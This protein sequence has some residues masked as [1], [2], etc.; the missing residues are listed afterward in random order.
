MG[1]LPSGSAYASN[2]LS[3]MD[4]LLRSPRLASQSQQQSSGRGQSDSASLAAMSFPINPDDFSQPP[5]TRRTAFPKPN[6]PRSL[7]PQ[8]IWQ[9]PMTQEWDW[10]DIAKEQGI[11]QQDNFPTI[12]HII[13]SGQQTTVFPGAAPRDLQSSSDVFELFAHADN[14]TTDDKGSTDD[15]SKKVVRLIKT[16]ISSSTGL[17]RRL[18]IMILFLKLTLTLPMNLTLV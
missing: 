10:F 12:N 9:M 15:D 4:S 5:A 14:N 8:D 11:S 3:Q 1:N 18:S 17:T 6:I 2:E 13:G 7:D 16:S